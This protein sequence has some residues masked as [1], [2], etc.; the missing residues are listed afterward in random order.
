MNGD[1]DA[2][3]KL[4][5]PGAYRAAYDPLSGFEGVCSLARQRR[6]LDFLRQARPRRV[7]EVGCGGMILA[8]AAAAEGLDW[9][10]WVVVEPEPDFVAAAQAATAGGPPVCIVSGYLEGQVATVRDLAPDGFEATLLSGLLH[11]TSDPVALLATAVGLT[12]AGG[13]V[14]AS[15]PN[16]RSFHRLLAVEA[17][18]IPSPQTLSP[19]DLALGHPVVFDAEGLDGLLRGAGLVDLQLDGYLFKPFTHAQMDQVIGPTDAA[20]VEGLIRLGR[21]FPANAAEICAIGRKP[22]RGSTFGPDRAKAA[23]P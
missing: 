11:E 16:A 15:V 10:L 23:R 19:R 6:N 13:Q 4:V 7:L 21:L 3:G 22:D 9:D 5:S 2:A 17:G 14:L 12:A 8:A 1:E 20:L 18:L